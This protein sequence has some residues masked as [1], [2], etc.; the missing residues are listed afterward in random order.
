MNKI[1]KIS[2][3]LLKHTGQNEVSIHEISHS[4][5]EDSEIFE[6]TDSGEV[7]IGHI[8]RNALFFIAIEIA[9]FAFENY[10]EDKNSQEFIRTIDYLSSFKRCISNNELKLLIKI[11]NDFFG[12]E[13]SYS[14]I[15]ASLYCT[16]KYL[17][18]QYIAH[19]A[20]TAFVKSRS[21]PAEIELRRQGNFIIDFLRSDKSLFL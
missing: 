8:S 15:P 21:A 20:S 9:E 6:I 19:S 14:K 17:S 16:Y 18:L 7:Y 3:H 2:N 13:Y 4:I 1:Y 5:A 12:G 11:S 10:F